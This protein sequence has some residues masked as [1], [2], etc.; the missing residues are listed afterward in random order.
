MD[1]L[2]ERNVIIMNRCSLCLANE[3]NEAHL[4]IH[5]AYASS[6][7]GLILEKFSMKWVMASTISELFQ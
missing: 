4:L 1:T 3:E 5:C 2:R 6:V 7:W